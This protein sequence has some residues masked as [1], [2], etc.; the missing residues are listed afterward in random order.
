MKFTRRSDFNLTPE[1][2]D[3]FRYLVGTDH[4]DGL[5]GFVYKTARVV[6]EMYPKRGTFIVAYRRL[7]YPTGACS[8]EHNEA[9]HIRN[10]KKIKV[11]RKNDP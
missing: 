8:P 6:K 2:V 1:S 7:I 11:S 9:I 5:D 4:R 10:I 3:D